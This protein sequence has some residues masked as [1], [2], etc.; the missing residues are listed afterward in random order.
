MLQIKPYHND[1]YQEMRHFEKEMRRTRA[2]WE[3]KKKGME[4]KNI[5]WHWTDKDGYKIDGKY[6]GEV[7]DGK[8]HG[9]GKWEKKDGSQTVEGEWKAGK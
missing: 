8:P 3:E 6:Q 4:K 9:L 1:F 2:E 5:N 7:K